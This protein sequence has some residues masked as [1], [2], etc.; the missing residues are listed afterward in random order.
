MREHVAMFLPDDRFET[1]VAFVLGC[2]AGNQNGLLVGFH[3]W[4]TLK[5]GDMDNLVW[6]AQVLHIAFPEGVPD[7]R[8]E[9]DNAQA[10]STLFDLLDE[11]L[12]SMQR[13][14]EPQLLL[15]EYFAWQQSKPGYE[16]W[17]NLRRYGVSPPPERALRIEETA[18][19]LGLSR[20]EVLDLVDAGQLRCGRE[21]PDLVFDEKTV[22]AYKERT[23]R[24][25]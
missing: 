15:Y 23:T 19:I 9:A 16:S 13:W 8:F 25:R 14:G 2:D 1:V 20:I 11:F 12:A 7:P 10:V 24:H 18:E 21:G 3:E 22:D 4:L 5:L 17:A 6:W